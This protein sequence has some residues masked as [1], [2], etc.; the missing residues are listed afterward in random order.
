MGTNLNTYSKDGLIYRVD[1]KINGVTHNFMD[2][3]ISKN[4]YLKSYR[5][6]KVLKLSEDYK[7]YLVSTASNTYILAYLQT[8]EVG[9]NKIKF[10]L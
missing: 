5:A 2:N 1:Y 4:K 9:F 7:F 3:I 8:S 6:D 10:S